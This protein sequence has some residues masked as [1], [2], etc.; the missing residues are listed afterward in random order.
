VSSRHRA[1]LNGLRF[2]VNAA[3]A[4]ETFRS[5]LSCRSPVPP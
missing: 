2:V 4:R 5:T 3:P 1:T